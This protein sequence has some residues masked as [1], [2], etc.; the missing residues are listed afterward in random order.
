MNT[1]S[2]TIA[3][4]FANDPD[5][6]AYKA[7]LV[8][9]QNEYANLLAAGYSPKEEDAAAIRQIMDPHET[10]AR[11]V[12]ALK[13]LATTADVRLSNMG[14]RYLDTIGTTNTHLLT[15]DSRNTFKNLGIPSKT[16]AV[17]QPIARGWQGGNA[18][19]INPAVLYTIFEAAGH[20]PVKAGQIAKDNGWLRP[21]GASY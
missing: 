5:W 3:K 2:D 12:S 4:Q 20:D 6:A 1:A 14:Q 19:P 17:S 16:D 10:P 18:T 7:S 9:V 13:Q 15:A 11:V 21:N 8:P